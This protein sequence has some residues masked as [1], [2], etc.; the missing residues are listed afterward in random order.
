MITTLTQTPIETLIEKLRE[1]LKALCVPAEVRIQDEEHYFEWA[2]C[3]RPE[4]KSSWTQEESKNAYMVAS[5]L[6]LWTQGMVWEDLDVAGYCCRQGLC[7]LIPEQRE[8][9]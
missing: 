3:A 5:S 2:I 4:G 9:M 1:G 7:Y 6:G 8:R